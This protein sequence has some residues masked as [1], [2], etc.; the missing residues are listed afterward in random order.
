MYSIYRATDEYSQQSRR[1][2]ALFPGFAA[3]FLI[4]PATLPNAVKLVDNVGDMCYI[5][6]VLGTSIDS[7]SRS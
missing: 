2:G 1:H 3:Q 5:F 6:S 4:T 7:L